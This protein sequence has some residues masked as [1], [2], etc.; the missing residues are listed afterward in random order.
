MNH[1]L[2]NLIPHRT[3]GRSWSVPGVG[4]PRGGVAHLLVADPG[5]ERRSAATLVTTNP[6]APPG[7][8][9]RSASCAGSASA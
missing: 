8:R 6:C 9:T 5:T 3:A 1:E 4:G 7:A 2:P